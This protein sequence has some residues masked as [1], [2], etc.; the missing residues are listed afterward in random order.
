MKYTIIAIFCLINLLAKA[1]IDTT[2]YAGRVDYSMQ[3]IN[4]ADISSG[5]LY[6]RVMKIS[7]IEEKKATDIITHS[8]FRQAY[9]EL[10]NAKYERSIM[11]N[12]TVIGTAAEQ[13]TFT[14]KIPLGFLYFK[15]NMLDSNAI[16]D[17]RLSINKAG[18]L[19]NVPKEPSPFLNKEVFL[20]TTLASQQLRVGKSTFSISLS[21]FFSDIINQIVRIEADFGNG[22]EILNITPA[23]NQDYKVTYTK[24]GTKTLTF[25]L[26]LTDGRTLTCLSQIKVYPNNASNSLSTIFKVAA[27]GIDYEIKFPYCFTEDIR[28]TEN[29]TPYEP[30]PF[31]ASDPNQKGY[32]TAHYYYRASTLVNT[33]T[34]ATPF[35]AVN[36]PALLKPFIIV[37]AFDPEDKRDAAEVYGSKLKYIEFGTGQFLGNQLRQQ[38]F[39]VIILNFPTYIMLA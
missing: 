7:G 21:L 10:Y 31:S 2:T 17:G 22:G 26:Y 19:Q 14:N 20:A 29:F 36:K 18:F 35:T 32:G 6:D 13:V 25:T 4:K 12:P 16:V 33:L 24:A 5:I 15:Y 30:E 1:Q 3:Y 37:E 38:G 11:P 23:S 8:N 28:A 27:D 34:C 39:D 9:Y